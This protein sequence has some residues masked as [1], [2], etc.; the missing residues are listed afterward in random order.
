MS[1]QLDKTI[2]QLSKQ[3]LGIKEIIKKLESQLNNF[4]DYH[5][6][7]QFLVSVGLYKTLVQSLAQQLRKEEHISWYYF[8]FIINKYQ[9]EMQSEMI[10]SFIS[11][12]SEDDWMYLFGSSCIKEDEQLLELQNTH[13]KNYYQNHE[14]LQLDLEKELQIAHS[15]KLLKK[16]KQIIDQLLKMDSKNLFFQKLKKE[17]E[18]KRAID[19][20]NE[21]KTTNTH[22]LYDSYRMQPSQK[23]MKQQVQ[24]IMEHFKNLAQT[25]PEHINDMAI[26]LISTGYNDLAIEFLKEHLNTGDRKWLYLELLLESK[27]FFLCLTFVDQLFSKNSLSSE[28]TFSLIY[29]KAQAYYGL[30]EYD[31]AQKTLEDLVKVRPRYRLAQELLSQWKIRNHL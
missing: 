1:T 12:S 22:Y 6:Y 30:K 9:T 19:T 24:K 26:I 17:Y 11:H 23:E 15:Q 18:R 28:E 16:E 7:Y 2:V 13:L 5:A 27:Q 8:F 10:E 25:K 20:L 14:N 21:Y 31:K 29:A 3:G 4:Q